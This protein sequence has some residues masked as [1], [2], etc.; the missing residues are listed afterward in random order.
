M[1]WWPRRQ[2]LDKKTFGAEWR[3]GIVFASQN[4]KHYFFLSHPKIAPKMYSVRTHYFR[5]ARFEHSG[6]KIWCAVDFPLGV[7]KEKR[8]AIR[9]LIRT[10]LR[11][12]PQQSGQEW[13]WYLREERKVG[14]RLGRWQKTFSAGANEKETRGFCLCKAVLCGFGYVIFGAWRRE[15]K[16]K[17]LCVFFFANAIVQL[18]PNIFFLLYSIQTLKMVYSHFGNFI[19]H[20]LEMNRINFAH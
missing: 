2:N 13:K 5:N 19:F 6:Q 7:R 16:S 18:S 11:I 12:A 4:N 14:K 3:S 9:N 17:A 20:S 15:Q 10:H 8:R 1:L